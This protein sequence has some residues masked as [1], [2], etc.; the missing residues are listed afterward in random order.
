MEAVRTS[1]PY[2]ELV[3]A[4]ESLSETERLFQVRDG[5]LGNALR[6]LFG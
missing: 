5:G 6:R 4:V 3:T 2:E 1:R